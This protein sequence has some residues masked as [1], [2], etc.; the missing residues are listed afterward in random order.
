MIHQLL[1]KNCDSL[2]LFRH[3][4]ERTFVFWVTSLSTS[5]LNPVIFTYL[6][7][8]FLSIHPSPHF[9]LQAHPRHLLSKEKKIQHCSFQLVSILFFLPLY[10]LKFNLPQSVFRYI[11]NNMYYK[12]LN[13]CKSWNV[14]NSTRWKTTL[15][16]KASTS[17]ASP[18][19]RGSHFYHCVFV[20][21]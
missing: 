8:H 18:F 9:C 21:R 15:P 4:I 19:L 14:L 1:F 11:L 16:P 3:L 10:F 17:S 2:S 20:Q 6:L 5:A 7:F 12:C 13:I